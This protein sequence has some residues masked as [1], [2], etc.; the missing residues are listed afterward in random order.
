MSTRRSPRPACPRRSPPPS[1][2]PWSTTAGSH[3]IDRR[4]TIRELLDHTSGLRD[5]F[6]D[7]RIDKALLSQPGRTWHASDTLRYVGKPYFTP[8]SG[9]HY[10][11]TNYFVLGLVAE[12]VGGAPVAQQLR[13]RFFEPLRLT[14]TTYQ[15]AEPPAA[16]PAHGYRFTGGATKLP[17]IDLSDGSEIVPFTSV[18]TAAAAAGSIATS[19]HDLVRWA[20]ALYGG[21]LLSAASF[22]QMLGDLT[23]TARYKPSVPYG[24]GVQATVID[25]R[26]A[27]GHSGR[28]LGSR[29]VVRWLPA[30][31]V[32][33]AVMTN[34]SRTD[35][36]VVARA[37]LKIAL[38]QPSVCGACPGG[39]GAGGIRCL[40][41]PESCLSALP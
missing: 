9:F 13:T 5:F 4:I 22:Q 32:G 12:A 11:N 41:A 6:F 26:P 23:R 3:A 16:A 7:R 24:L 40:A 17:P 21:H 39:G 36:A 1:S 10:S 34:Q 18:V 37:L 25:G 2:W 28:L 15:G 27:I 8:G 29:A 20:Q 33:I 14:D 30:D 31:A 19:S 35:P 38:V